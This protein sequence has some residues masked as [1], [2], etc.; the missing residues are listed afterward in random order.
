MTYKFVEKPLTHYATLLGDLF[1]KK[2]IFFQITLDFMIYTCISI[3]SMS[4]HGGV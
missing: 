1:G 4:K 2:I 3:N